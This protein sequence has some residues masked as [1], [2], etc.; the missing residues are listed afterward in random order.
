MILDPSS[1]E[2]K[3]TIFPRD[4]SRDY[5]EDQLKLKSEQNALKTHIDELIAKNEADK[6]EHTAKQIHKLQETLRK[7]QLIHNMDT[8]SPKGA[9]IDPYIAAAFNTVL[10]FSGPIIEN[11]QPLAGGS[12]DQSVASVSDLQNNFLWRAI[13]PQLPN[14]KPYYN[15]AGKYAVKLFLGG[16]WRK[17]YVN[18]AI[19]LRADGTVALSTSAERLELWPLILAKAI[20][21]VYSV[22]G[23]SKR[24]DDVNKAAL[25]VNSFVTTIPAYKVSQ[26][27]SFALHLLTSWQPSVPVSLGNVFLKEV[28]KANGLL[29][30]LLLGGVID[31][32][33]NDIVTDEKS[34]AQPPSL[35][36]GS[37]Q[38]HHRN[39]PVVLEDGFYSYAKDCTIRTALQLGDEAS[40]EGGPVNALKTKKQFQIDYLRRKATRDEIV[41]CILL[42]E[43][44]IRKFE[45]DFR[46]TPMNEVYFLTLLS[47]ETSSSRVVPVLGVMFP[48]HSNSLMDIQ[49]LVD[50]RTKPAEAIP[51]EVVSMQGIFNPE[52]LKGRE[53]AVVMRR[54]DETPLPVTT[55]LVYEWLTVKQLTELNAYVTAV[56]TNI[57][58]PYSAGYSRHWSP[59]TP[60]VD[61]AAATGKKEKEAK[62]IKDKNKSGI[63]P[64][65][66]APDEVLCGDDGAAPITL[67][68]LDTSMVVFDS[69][70]ATSPP[71]SG[72]SGESADLLEGDEVVEDSDFASEVEEALKS[73]QSEMSTVTPVPILPTQL[74]PT[75]TA[76]QA[77]SLT[78][79]DLHNPADYIYM[80]VLIHADLVTAPPAA[81]TD[82]ASSTPEG[83]VSITP[84]LVTSRPPTASRPTTAGGSKLSS[85]GEVA[86]ILRPKSALFEQKP[87]E[88]P[89]DTVVILQEVRFDDKDPLMYIIDLKDECYLPFSRKTFG[90]PKHRLSANKNEPMLF[91]VRVFSRSSIYIQINSTV[92]VTIDSAEKIWTGLNRPYYSSEGD[93]TLT[94]EATEQLLFR[95]PLVGEQS[96]DSAAPIASESN[97]VSESGDQSVIPH[98]AAT[99][100][101]CMAF[102]HIADRDV[103]KAVS[104]VVLNNKHEGD[105]T[106][107]TL[108]NTQGNL[109]NLNSV[110][111]EANT[112]IG[113]VYPKKLRNISGS[114]VTVAPF[115]W[116]LLILSPAAPVVTPSVKPTISEEAVTQRYFGRYY[117]N[118]K[119]ALFRDVFTVEKS[120]FPI[121][122]RLVLSP[123]EPPVEN[124]ESDSD[125]PIAS[126]ED[127]HVIVRTYRKSDQ[128]LVSTFSGQRVCHVYSQSIDLFLNA[129]EDSGQS[130]SAPV[131]GKKDAKA[132]PPK[133][134]AVVAAET[135]DLIVE[136]T[137]DT[138]KCDASL[139]ARF[140]SRFPHNFDVLYDATVDAATGTETSQIS[141]F[142]EGQKACLALAPPVH[143][144]FAWQLDILAGKVTNVSHDISNLERFTASK[145]AWEEK[146]AGRTERA[147]AALAYYQERRAVERV[148]EDTEGGSEE[149]KQNTSS[150]LTS[151]MIES[152]SVALNVADGQSGTIDE[153]TERYALIHRLPKY[154]EFVDILPDD[155]EQQQS[156][157]EK[158]ENILIPPSDPSDPECVNTVHPDAAEKRAAEKAFSEQ[159]FTDA[160]AQFVALNAMLRENV[161]TRVG[162]MVQEA[163]LDATE[164]SKLW[165]AREAYRVECEVKNESLKYLLTRAKE[166]VQRAKDI[167]NGWEVVSGQSDLGIIPYFFDTTTGQSFWSHPFEDEGEDHSNMELTELDI[168]F[169]HVLGV[170]VD[171]EPHAMEL[172]YLAKALLYEL[173][174]TWEISVSV[175]EEMGGAAV[176]IFYDNESQASYWTHPFEASHRLRIEEARA[177][178]RDQQMA[179][180]EAARGPPVVGMVES[181]AETIQAVEP[182][183]S[184][185]FEESVVAAESEVVK[186][187]EAVAVTE[188]VQAPQETVEA[189][190]PAA[191]DLQANPESKKISYVV[192]ED[193]SVGVV[194]S[195]DAEVP[196]VVVVVEEPVA[197]LSEVK[198]NETIA[199]SEEP[200]KVSVVEEPS[201]VVES[202]GAEQ[203]ATETH[204]ADSENDD[205]D[206]ALLQQLSVKAVTNVDTASADLVRSVSPPPQEQLI[207]DYL[208]SEDFSGVNIVDYEQV[209]SEAKENEA[210]ELEAA[211]IA[212][213]QLLAEQEQQRLVVEAAESERVAAQ[214]AAREAV[215]AE[216]AAVAAREAEAAATAAASALEL[217]QT[218]LSDDAVEAATSAEV[219]SL[220]SEGVEVAM[221]EAVSQAEE[222]RL[223][224]EDMT[225]SATTAALN[226][227]VDETLNDCVEIVVTSAMEAAEDLARIERERANA[228][229]PPPLLLDA[230][231]TSPFK[232]SDWADEDEEGTM[233]DLNHFTLPLSARDIA[234]GASKPVTPFT[235]Q[236]EVESLSVAKKVVSVTVPPPAAVEEFPTEVFATPIKST[237]LAVTTS[238]DVAPTSPEM[239]LVVVQS[240]PGGGGGGGDSIHSGGHSAQTSVRSKQSLPAPVDALLHQRIIKVKTDYLKMLRSNKITDSKLSVVST[241]PNKQEHDANESDDSPFKHN[242]KQQQL[243]GTL[244]TD[245]VPD[246][247][248]SPAR[249]GQFKRLAPMEPICSGV[250][251]TAI[252]GLVNAPIVFKGPKWHL[253]G[254]Y[255]I[256][257]EA[258]KA[259]QVIV[260]L[261]NTDS[262]GTILI[263][264]RDNFLDSQLE[265]EIAAEKQEKERLKTAALV[266][267]QSSHSLLSSHGGAFERHAPTHNVNQ[268]SMKPELI[269]GRMKS[270]SEKTVKIRIR[271][272]TGRM[273]WI[274][275][276]DDNA[277]RKIVKRH[278]KKGKVEN[279]MLENSGGNT[280]KR[281]TKHVTPA[282]TAETLTESKSFGLISKIPTSELSRS[283][284]FTK[285]RE[286]RSV[287]REAYRGSD[288]SGGDSPP[289]SRQHHVQKP[290]SRALQ[291]GHNNNHEE[292]E[293][294]SSELRHSRSEA[295]GI[296]RHVQSS[297]GP[298]RLPNI[299]RNISS[300]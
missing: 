33:D 124:E 47:A 230:I 61:P 159:R 150:T 93:S 152:L 149:E 70:R 265:A 108:H 281:I 237:A 190:T 232:Y 213:A 238:D 52:L 280:V 50:W 56:N 209:A 184:V 180:E 29:E 196:S 45:E 271:R 41:R 203:P 295:S 247:T 297:E 46:A 35:G 72:N 141:S 243:K 261:V 92:K 267:A 114:G 208:Q 134:G 65:S 158:E 2:Y 183:T 193:G 105:T 1:T 299:S 171:N 188:V 63:A 76:Q 14:G 81:P 83:T 292:H 142:V 218:R 71:A 131:T 191:I 262:F 15:S 216:L 220:Y 215:E 241:S 234:V 255:D 221:S 95:M 206:E 78:P 279:S 77:G 109:L 84:G 192:A 75:D 163:V 89:S 266:N 270:N 162:S 85:I 175:S 151:T 54:D 107:S 160:A 55:P 204:V 166:A 129:G 210:K 200:E 294:R 59:L 30:S 258:V 181:V 178:L 227:T 219:D 275:E 273:Q 123:L 91:W 286:S 17:V 168:L 42:R 194:A 153:V 288:D 236:V 96:A 205:L 8:E 90:I 120:S 257:K 6:D 259:R 53:N 22:C 122:M 156:G 13:Y 94:R 228:F 277:V 24:F 38:K 74:I 82:G 235:V 179:D 290:R 137:L 231:S 250:P 57:A 144:Q 274:V 119:L 293:E 300:T 49:F 139:I 222:I 7:S 64:A 291:R 244:F 60:P 16:K 100:W 246:F 113:T 39:E 116:K 186:S 161:K 117:A 12:N 260:H 177:A 157:E 112:L 164:M 233:T 99:H 20:Y 240:S 214:T 126:T 173:P 98:S 207:V 58:I 256:H 10:R 26:F 248:S 40:S 169:A 67:L 223:R 185:Q 239:H 226:S 140:A 254:S 31:I 121:A 251:A 143:A 201:L 51:E 66:L 48:D 148:S 97:P 103:E 285:D 68:L 249:T 187:P 147:A 34:N 128:S 211:A 88:L 133:K 138:A 11:P 287:T 195:E 276:T 212:A 118:N 37:P 19:P 170:D 111:K 102:L 224:E 106:Y 242:T 263:D 264:P 104:L 130:S 253:L 146:S 87:K 154:V 298:M 125:A 245:I 5:T 217:E 269:I 174:E 182:V 86:S 272:D 3:A 268:L 278:R 32:M 132:P 21:T 101:P 225:M 135:V 43:D 73:Q 229:V 172:C 165:A 197:I 80:S 145:N 283:L 23:Y 296:L 27:T 199:I 202:N 115:H 289:H 176:P 167:E 25:S 18:D 252:I 9:H 79:R 4:F 155:E 136:C 28:S 110:S 198:E 189:E 69:P 127:V 282:P 62:P 284:P 36:H 44:R